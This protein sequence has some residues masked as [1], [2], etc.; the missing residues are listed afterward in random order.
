MKTARTYHNATCL[1][2]GHCFPGMI[3][4]GPMVFDKDCYIDEFGENLEVN[5]QSEK[6]QKWLKKHKETMGMYEDIMKKDIEDLTIK[7]WSKK[8]D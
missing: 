6:Y 1:K 3:M 8:N 7:E 4:I 2:C 5:P